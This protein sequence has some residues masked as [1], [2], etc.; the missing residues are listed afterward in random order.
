MQMREWILKEL[1]VDEGSKADARA[2]STKAKAKPKKK[3][4]NKA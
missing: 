1:P 2:D 3:K 4:A